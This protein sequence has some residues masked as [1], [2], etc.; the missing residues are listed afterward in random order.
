VIAT[1][2]NVPWSFV[3]YTT[4]ASTS[5]LPVLFFPLS[6]THWLALDLGTRPMLRGERPRWKTFR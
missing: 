6:R 3:G 5:L 2:P 4:L 1:L